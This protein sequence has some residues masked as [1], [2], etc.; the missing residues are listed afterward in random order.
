M[1]TVVHSKDFD[2]PRIYPTSQSS[3][4]FQLKGFPTFYSNENEYILPVNLWLNY[5][6]NIRSISD[7]SCSVRA[8]KRYW[9]FLEDTG[10]AW[11]AFPPTDY[12]KPTYRFR[13][14][15]L[16]KAAKK[17]E[18]AYSTASLYMLHIIKFYEWA[19]H[20]RFITFTEDNKPFSYQLVHIANTGMMNHNNPKFVVRSTDLRIRKPARNENQKL[21]P[22]SKEELG[23]LA[24]CL[25]GYSEEF[26]IHQLLQLQ[27]GLRVEEACTFP[28]ASVEKPDLGTKRFEVEIG[29]SNGVHT[30]FNKTRKVEIPLSLMQRMYYYS[31]SERR[32]VRARK[33][34]KDYSHL[35][36]NNR[37]LPICSNNIQQYFRR[38][39][40]DIRSRFQTSFAHRTHDL[41]ATYGT[42]RL[43]AL[44]D[45]LPVGDALALVMAWMGHKDDKTTW[46]YLKYLRKEK[47]NQS[48]MVLLDQILEESLK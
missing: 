45:H 44:L 34:T 17:G 36:L 25:T 6:Q 1:V 42:Y 35:L 38:L 22:L 5:L 37:G 21:N 48:S 14:D 9:Q 47:A 15:D 46:K 7:I 24:I 39:R 33:T 32:F 26:I 8:I 27:S 28:I 29:P 23:Q 20:E 19:A 43:D 10:C 40:E 11:N 16:L 2:V 41:R 3:K 30:K 13:N 12:L 4:N 18:I 31:I